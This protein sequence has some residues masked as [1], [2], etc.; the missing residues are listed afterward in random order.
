MIDI[1]HENHWLQ[2]IKH[3]SGMLDSK[4]ELAAPPEKGI[5]LGHAFSK[6]VEDGG[7]LLKSDNSYRMHLEWI[8]QSPEVMHTVFTVLWKEER[9]THLLKF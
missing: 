3:S 7:Q 4:T 1:L 6:F 5:F 9:K 2:A 8:M